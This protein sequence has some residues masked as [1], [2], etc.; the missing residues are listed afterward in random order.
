[1]FKSPGPDAM[2]PRVLKELK[3]EIVYPLKV[4][5]ESSLENNTLPY[6]WKSGNITPI[7]KKGKKGDVKN[8][9]P[10]SITSIV[11]KILESIVRD[12]LI[13][14]F[15]ENNL[16][17]NKQYGFIKGRSTVSQLLTLMDKWTE[18]LEQGGQVD[19]IYTDLEKAFDKVPHEQ[20]IRKLKSYKINTNI[21][22]WINSF[23]SDRRQRVRISDSFSKWEKVMS[24][25]PQGSILGP[26]L[27][28]IYINDLEDSCSENSHVALY[29][30]DTKLYKY[31]KHENDAIKLQEDL[32]NISV[33]IND[34]LLSLNIEKC[35]VISIG[36]NATIDFQYK[37]DDYE[38][39]KL[40]EIKDLGVTFD[41]KLKFTAHINDKVNK[42]FSVLG[43][44]NRNFKYMERNTFIMLYKSM[45]RPHLE[46]ANL[47]WHPYRKDEI[48]K[49]EKVQ[50]RATKLVSSLKT[51]SYENRLKKLNLPTLSFRRLRGDMI[52]VYKIVTGKYGKNNSLELKSSSNV[53]TRGNQYKLYQSQSRLDIRKF[54]F[55]NRVVAAWNSL[56]DYVVAVNSTVLFKKHLDKFWSNQ[57]IYFNFEA[58]L[59]GTGS[60]SYVNF[61][62]DIEA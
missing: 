6:D 16:F 40:Y 56:P 53:N 23:L 31:V 12:S 35:K 9:R 24:G 51:L 43:V 39:E 25:I 37:I 26:L 15:Q 48:N 8:Y 58:E 62:V 44:I 2:H 20:L 4:I 19:V 27:F 1:V 38:L 29:A 7:Y 49:L 14:H 33:W 5:F 3:N 42:A 52:E 21:I 10:V 57:S 60:R 45:V 11:G 50:R 41:S 34:W 32:N 13:K 54:F 55:T 28:I 47:V 59:E 30:D 61:D 46:Y 22:N 18:A 36:R 17:S